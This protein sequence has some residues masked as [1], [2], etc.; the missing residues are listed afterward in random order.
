VGVGKQ[1]GELTGVLWNQWI[2]S[3]LDNMYVEHKQE[4]KADTQDTHEG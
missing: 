1:P 4:C 3:I 2:L